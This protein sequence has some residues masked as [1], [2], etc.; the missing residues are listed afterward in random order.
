MMAEKDGAERSR[1]SVTTHRALAAKRREIA[2]RIDARPDVSALFF[3]NPVLAL[4]EVGVDLSPEI[5]DH[6]LR[7]LRHPPAAAARR[8]ELET[9]LREE[10]GEAPKVDDERW[11]AR[12]VFERLRVQPLATRGHH[13][14]HVDPI[15]G[16]R[17]LIA[18]L[19]P[20]IPAFTG[21]TA[22][23]PHGMTIHV[24]PHRATVRRLDIDAPVPELPPVD[25]PPK[26]LAHETLWFYK[27]AHPVVRDLF[28]LGIIEGSALPIHSGDSYRQIKDGTKPNAFAAW[29][30]SVRFRS[31]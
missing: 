4:K 14:A 26:T 15:A 3:I 11:L 24:A 20:A 30:K 29:I 2:A 13:P 7:A 28:E 31:P 21:A 16:D 19:R 9:S 17:A 10:L 1:L 6:V 18:A 23:P 27:D 8:A 22:T 12:V 5:A 25:V